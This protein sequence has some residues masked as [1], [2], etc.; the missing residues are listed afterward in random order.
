MPIDCK[1]ILSVGELSVRKNHRVV[2][3]ALQSLPGEYW[4]VIVGKGDLKEELEKFD[5]TGRLKLLGFRTDIVDLLHSSDLFVFPSLQEGLPVALMEVMAAGFPC[6][7]SDIRGNRDLMKDSLVKGNELL[8]W[9]NA[10]SKGGY[11]RGMDSFSKIRVMEMMR[12][13]YSEL[14]N[15][16][17]KC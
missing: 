2:V 8:S 12:K 13:L 16:K 11:N 10:L 17:E 15:V 3:E 9:K 14:K 7:A 6:V 4:Y 1:L 5:H